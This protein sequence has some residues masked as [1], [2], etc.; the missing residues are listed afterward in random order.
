MMIENS[1]QLWCVSHWG[2]R[3]VRGG[4]WILSVLWSPVSTSLLLLVGYLESKKLCLSFLRSPRVDCRSG[5]CPSH[6]NVKSVLRGNLHPNKEDES[7][8]DWRPKQLAWWQYLDTCANLDREWNQT[9]KE[10]IHPPRTR[11]NYPLVKW[12]LFKRGRQERLNVCESVQNRA[13]HTWEVVR[14]KWMGELKIASPPEEITYFISKYCFGKFRVCCFITKPGAGSKFRLFF[15]LFPDQLNTRNCW[16]LTF[17]KKLAEGSSF[18][19]RPLA[20]LKDRS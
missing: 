7:D 5:D 15:R 19:S 13:Y 17:F 10:F 12:E 2:C 3:C 4:S 6:S 9:L 16:C 8:P 20:L 11:G 18:M 14:P 1:L